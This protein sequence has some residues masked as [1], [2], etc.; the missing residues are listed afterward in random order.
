L[1]IVFAFRAFVNCN[2]LM[3][4]PI[5]PMLADAICCAAATA[6]MEQGEE[7]REGW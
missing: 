4:I 2:G 5:A 1:I 3:N 6:V 7:R